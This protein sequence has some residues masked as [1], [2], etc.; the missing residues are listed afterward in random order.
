MLLIGR[1]MSPFTRRVAVTLGM[2]DLE[3]EYQSLTAWNNLDELRR[4]NPVGRIPA[5]VLEGGEVLVDSAAILDY[6]DE[7]AGPERALIPPTGQLRRDVLRL[8]AVA[9]GAMEKAAQVRWERALRPPEKIHEPWIEHNRGQVR[10]A[11]E[12]LEAQVPGQWMLRERLTQADISIAVA[13]EFFPLVDDTLFTPSAYPYLAGM[14]AKMR[15]Y[16][17][18]SK[19]RPVT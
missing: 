1:N 6:L 4:L 7:F 12:W 14:L 3:F 5:L 16:A 18:F 9:V 11:L 13:C 8:T 19:T 17:A 10:S 2:L 15:E